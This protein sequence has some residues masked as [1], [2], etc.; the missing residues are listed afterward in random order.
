MNGTAIPT[1]SPT[2]QPTDQPS[3]PTIEP[4]Y[5]PTLEPTL[6]TLSPTNKPTSSVVCGTN[7]HCY[8]VNIYPQRD[9]DTKWNV[10]V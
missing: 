7:T 4:T 10:L 9:I 6:P 1:I 2:P 5:N 3:I 8:N